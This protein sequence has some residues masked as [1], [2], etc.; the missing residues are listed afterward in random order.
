MDVNDTFKYEPFR[1]KVVST[2]DF[3]KSPKKL[4]LWAFFMSINEVLLKKIDLHHYFECR[5]L[6]C[7]VLCEII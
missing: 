1:E 3:Q 4:I 7:N 5:L 6:N 2:L